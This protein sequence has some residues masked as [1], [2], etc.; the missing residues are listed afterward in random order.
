MTRGRL[1]TNDDIADVAKAAAKE[2]IREFALLMGID[3]SDSKSVLEAQ[4]DFHW[5]RS[6]RGNGDAAKRQGILTAVAVGVTAAL[7]AAWAYL[8]GQATP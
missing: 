3:A 5:L 1:F 6:A 2:T 7:G 8:G 4:K